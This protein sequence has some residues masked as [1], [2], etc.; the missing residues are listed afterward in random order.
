MTAAQAID[1]QRTHGVIDE[2][3]K[4][5]VEQIDIEIADLG[6]R[7]IDVEFEAG[8]A[9]QINNDPRQGL[10]QWHISMAIAADGTF[11]T[12]RFMHRHA[13]R[14]ADVFDRV[15]GVDD[16]IAIGLDIDIDEAVTHDLVEH[17]IE[18]RNAGRERSETAAI[19][20]DAD[21]DL[22]FFGVARDAGG[23]SG[24]RIR[25]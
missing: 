8:P 23:T 20:I 14:D 15:V 19:E 17:V 22:R 12:E 16:E 3:L 2:T 11:V 13:E 25:L 10:V 21:G 5:F 24:H 18:K 1:V 6:A 4:E 7:K 9:R